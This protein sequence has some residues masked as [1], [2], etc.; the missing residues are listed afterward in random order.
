MSRLRGGIWR[1]FGLDGLGFDL[2]LGSTWGLCW[3]GLFNFIMMMMMMMDS[4]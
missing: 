2:G 4:F 1:R 3:M